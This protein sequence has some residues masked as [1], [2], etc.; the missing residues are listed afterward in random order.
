MIALVVETVRELISRGEFLLAADH[1]V[2]AIDPDSDG[3]DLELVW[4]TALALARSGATNRAADL[5]TDLDV[6]AKA[7]DAPAQLAEDIGALWARLAKDQ[8]FWATG[9]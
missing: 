6:V 5:L 2:E 4:A 7:Q 3:N 8:S 1:G 9:S